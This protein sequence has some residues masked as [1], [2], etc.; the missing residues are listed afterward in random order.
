V[1]EDRI[2]AICFLLQREYGLPRHGNKA[3]PLDELIYII[4]STRTGPSAYR[5]MYAAI[6][7]RFPV[8][9]SLTDADLPELQ[10]LLRPA[11]LGRLKA[12]QI[13]SIINSLKSCFG[14]PTLSP[15][16]GFDDQEAERFLVS[17]PGVSKKIAKCVLMY[18]LNRQVLPVDAHVHRLALRLGFKV[19]K[20]PDTSQEIIET[21][22]PPELRY[23]F[24]VDAIAHSR[25]I[26][27]A[28]SP[29][30][31]TCCVNRFCDYYVRGCGT[32]A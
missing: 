19:K 28:R 5:R 21:A 13:T 15:L 17:L 30:C 18:S 1:N 7:T 27:K 22:V 2:R 32:Y 14:K 25:T 12:L 9:D 29:L 23:G 10:A 8:W 16:A 4:L 3:D 6:K 31:S 24:H 11:G 26:C 20:R